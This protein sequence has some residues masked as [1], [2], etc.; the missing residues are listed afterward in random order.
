[1]PL[2]ISR[3]II[4]TGVCILFS[5]TT[6]FLSKPEKGM[7]TP[8]NDSLVAKVSILGVFHFGGSSQDMASMYMPDPFGERRQADI[9]NLVS[10]LAD[11]KPTK[12]LVEYPK[13]LQIRLDEKYQSYLLGKDTLSVNETEQVGFRLAKLLGHS[14]LYAIDYSLDLPGDGLFEYCQRNDKMSEFEDFISNIR[15][16]VSNE[17]KILDTMSISSYLAR[18]NVDAIDQ[19]TNETYVGKILNWG[20]SVN[21]AGARFAATWWERN[22]VILRNIAQTIENKEERVLVIIGSGHRAVL[23]DLMINRSDMEYVEISNYLK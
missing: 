4:G 14:K 22:M 23:K 13:H 12:I 1:M 20:D 5:I 3:I 21:E 19:F 9:S 15:S 7:I 16:Y 8:T 2:S 6:G 18:T 11:F 10:K 17:N